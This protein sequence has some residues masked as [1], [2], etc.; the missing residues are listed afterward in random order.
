MILALKADGEYLRV[1]D[2]GPIV[3]IYPFD[4]NPDLKNRIYKLKKLI[5]MRSK[6]PSQAPSF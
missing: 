3:V 5:V 2:K 1:R 6:M 4:Q